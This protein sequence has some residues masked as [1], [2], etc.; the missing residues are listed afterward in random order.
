VFDIVWDFRKEQVPTARG[1]GVCTPFLDFVWCSRWSQ[2]NI[3]SD[4]REDKGNGSATTGT[5][6]TK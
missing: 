5:R 6:V 3:R 2:A 4:Q 1:A